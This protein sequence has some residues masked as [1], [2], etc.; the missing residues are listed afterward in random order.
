MSVRL[1]QAELKRVE[2]PRIPVSAT[3]SDIVPA[4]TF[5]LGLGFIKAVSRSIFIVAAKRCPSKS[6]R[7]I[8]WPIPH[9]PSPGKREWE[10]SEDW[11]WPTAAM[12]LSRRVASL[13]SDAVNNV[14][15]VRPPPP[16]STPNHVSRCF[17][18]HSSAVPQIYDSRRVPD[19]P[20]AAAAVWQHSRPSHVAR[21]SVFAG[22]QA[23]TD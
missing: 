18:H 12:E 3:A 13:G 4:D 15:P 5:L 21:L 1:S 17:S 11:E 16:V 19:S 22:K 14:S 8:G 20:A 2:Y 6:P 23:S 10:G 9:Q 7:L